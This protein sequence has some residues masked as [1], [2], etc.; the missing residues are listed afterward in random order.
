MYIVVVYTLYYLSIVDIND[1]MTPEKKEEPNL[2]QDCGKRKQ[3]NTPSIH[4]L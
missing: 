2:Q 1:F 3:F 4:R